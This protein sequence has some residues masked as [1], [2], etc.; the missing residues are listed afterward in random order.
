VDRVGRTVALCQAERRCLLEYYSK[1]GRVGVAA[2]AVGA[3]GKVG[4]CQDLALVLQADPTPT[5]VSHVTAQTVVN[6]RYIYLP[7][8]LCSFAP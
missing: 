8:V 3:V 7:V 4:S 2:A 6:P 1:C 5:Y